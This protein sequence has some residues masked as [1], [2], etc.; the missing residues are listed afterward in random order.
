MKLLNDLP[1]TEVVDCVASATVKQ[2]TS[3]APGLIR[4]AKLWN[5]TE[6]AMQNRN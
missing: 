5:D 4:P 3:Q 6:T 2:A 1:G